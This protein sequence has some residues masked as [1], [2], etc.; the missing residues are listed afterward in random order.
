MSVTCFTSISFSY[1]AKARVLGWSLKRHHP[2][3]TL[4]ICITDKEPDGFSFDLDAEP[5][6]R[7]IYATE[8]GIDN[9]EGWLF[10]HDVVEACTAVKGPLL[11]NLLSEG[12]EKVFYID[13]DIAVFE[14]LQPLVD[15]LDGSSV[16]LTPHQVAPDYEDGS[17]QDNEI[18]GS[19]KHGTYNLGFVAVRNSTSGMEFA[20]WWADRCRRYCYDDPDTAVF[21]DQKWCDLV[22]ALFDEVHI[23][24][25]PGY[26]V[27]SWNLNKRTLSVAPDGKILINGHAPLRFFHFTKLGPIGDAMTRRYAGDNVEVYEIWTWYKHQVDEALDEA[28]PEKWWFYGTY[29]NGQPISKEARVLYRHR[30]DLQRAFPDPFDA[31]AGGFLGWYLNEHLPRRA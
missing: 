29:S 18:S 4:C 14:T 25:D 9:V 15:Q 7:V 12:A 28:I 3:W 6:D 16:L 31:T 11:L 27:A 30:T 8:L 26:N 2:E 19:L 22:P 21:V 17:I 5:F 23:V 24:R 20:R 1:L 13:P 10:K